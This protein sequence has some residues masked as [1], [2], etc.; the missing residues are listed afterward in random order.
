MFL[1]SAHS[2]QLNQCRLSSLK[3]RENSIYEILNET[4]GKLKSLTS[5]ESEY[6]KLLESLVLQVI[7][8]FIPLYNHI[9]IFKNI[10]RHF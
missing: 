1:I 2:N 7:I 5:N 6:K 9:L 10:I 3:A 4:Q 8:F